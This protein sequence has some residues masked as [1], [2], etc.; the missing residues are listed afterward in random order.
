M[1]TNS[2]GR[3]LS[4]GGM[5]TNKYT[6]NALFIAL[7]DNNTFRDRFLTYMGEMMATEWTT[8]KVIEKFHTRYDELMTEMPRHGERWGMSRSSFESQIEELVDYAR[9]RPARLLSSSRRACTFPDDQMRHYF[10]DAGAAIRA[11]EAGG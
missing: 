9:T 8:E 5:G 7:M 11:Y 2:I 1:D 6:D 10:G 3:W 4:P